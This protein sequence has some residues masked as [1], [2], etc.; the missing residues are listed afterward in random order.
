MIQNS[1]KKFKK[2]LKQIIFSEKKKNSK[3][4]G[5][6][7]FGKMKKSEKNNAGK[8]AIFFYQKPEIGK[9]KKSKFLDI[10][11]HFVCTLKIFC[12][13]TLWCYVV[14]QKIFRD[15]WTPSGY[16]KNSPKLF[17]P[18]KRLS[19]D[20][21]NYIPPPPCFLMISQG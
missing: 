14:F 9:T 20:I 11:V 10:F 5:I 17:F 1:K 15:V 6:F 2:K 4:I 16:L 19:V 21:T 18:K 7:F 13:T 12:E 8:C 3:K